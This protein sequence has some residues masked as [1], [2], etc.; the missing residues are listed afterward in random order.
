MIWLRAFFSDISD[1]IPSGATQHAAYRNHS[2]YIKIKDCRKKQKKN[3]ASKRRTENQLSI[4][5]ILSCR[6]TIVT[7]E[8]LCGISYSGRWVRYFCD[9]YEIC[10]SLLSVLN[11]PEFPPGVHPP[12]L[13]KIWVSSYFS[14]LLFFK[15]FLN[16]VQKRSKNSRNKI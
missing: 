3:A 6:E 10:C 16:V 4:L 2:A 14:V 7:P 15:F 5:E 12:V 1:G 11:R 9:R 13:D 8:P